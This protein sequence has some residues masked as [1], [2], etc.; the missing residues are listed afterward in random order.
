MAQG[1]TVAV[2]DT[3]KLAELLGSQVEIRKSAREGA[4]YPLYLSTCCGPLHL[5]TRAGQD[6]L[7][8]NGKFKGAGDPEP[9]PENPEPAPEPRPEP[10]PGNPET[11]PAK[12]RQRFSLFTPDEDLGI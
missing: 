6:F 2:I 11:R 10:S 9:A 3:A 8:E 5:N 1:N 7:L 4:K 12:P